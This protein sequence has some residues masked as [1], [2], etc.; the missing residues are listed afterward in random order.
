MW[1]QYERCEL[2][3]S[4]RPQQRRWGQAAALRSSRHFRQVLADHTGLKAA[5]LGPRATIGK[6]G[7]PCGRSAL[8][9]SLLSA[10]AFDSLN[11]FPESRIGTKF[12]ERRINL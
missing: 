2:S 3:I 8:C 6:G 5:V 7:A 4:L 9:L 11:Q 12:V 1:H 10:A